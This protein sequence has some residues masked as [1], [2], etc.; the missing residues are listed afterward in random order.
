MQPTHWDAI[1]RHVMSVFHIKPRRWGVERF[2]SVFLFTLLF[3][4]LSYPA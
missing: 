3:V 1:R 2:H 4:S